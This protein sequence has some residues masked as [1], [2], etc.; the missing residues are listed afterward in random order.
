MYRLVSGLYA[1][2]SAILLVR[3]GG[4]AYQAFHYKN[5]LIARGFEPWPVPNIV[6]LVIGLEPFFCSLPARSALLGLC[7]AHGSEAALLNEA[8]A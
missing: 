4:A 7:A 6:S 8:K 1:F 2:A 3:F 5:L